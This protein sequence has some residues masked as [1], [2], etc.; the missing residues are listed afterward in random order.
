MRE[1]FR[2]SRNAEG[3]FMVRLPIKEGIQGLGILR[4]RVKSH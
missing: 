2:L 1:A 4:N 3:R